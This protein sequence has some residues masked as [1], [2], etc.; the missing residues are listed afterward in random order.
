[1]ANRKQKA[2]LSNLLDGMEKAHKAEIQLYTSGHLNHDKL[3]RPKESIKRN[4]WES[5]KKSALFLRKRTP[6]TA[7][8][9]VPRKPPTPL[10]N[11]GDATTPTS[12]PMS[13][14]AKP[15]SG[16]GYQALESRA[17]PAASECAL[18]GV[19]SFKL[20]RKAATKET[21]EEADV[22]QKPLIREELDIPGLKTLKYKPTLNSR[23][24]VMEPTKDEYQF[25][26][27]YLAGVTKTDQFHSFM[28]F[29][30]N[31]IAQE[32]LLDNDYIGSKSAEHHEKKL[33]QALRNICD[34]HRPHFNR[35]QAVGDVFEDICN[36]SL[37]FGDILK[38]VKN[39]YELYMMIL[40]DA[41]P[42]MQYRMLQKEVKGME[43]RTVKTH[44]IEEARHE[45]QILVQKSKCALERNEEL[46][47][48][49][50]IEL[51]LSQSVSETFESQEA[52]KEEAPLSNIEQLASLRCKILTK[53]EEIKAME[54]EIKDTM[55]FA[56]ITNIKE[57]TIKELEAEAAKLKASNKFLKK[58][59][60]DV[61]HTI[62]TT[63]NSQKLTMDNQRFFWTL[64][65]DFLVPEGD[66][67][68]LEDL[69]G[70]FFRL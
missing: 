48:E 64:V 9:K 25:L 4:Y 51:Y 52:I 12:T 43:K 13:T 57:K 53:W 70:S 37:I 46:R 23:L 60:A 8:K 38:E 2:S 55:V 17:D 54:K 30:K 34:C 63:L 20:Q 67:D 3:Y 29:Q 58:Q 45:I 26:P 47:N 69:G 42:T 62:T 10:V 36:S 28:K 50:E 7:P 56:G 14:D 18:L 68:L 32:D 35:M 33:T 11:F 21:E 24:C 6:P 39:E 27:S 59:I 16:S 1:M 5:A 66:E 61:E 40:M 19:T 22:S 49:L 65:K 44:E 41:L 31:V 15:G